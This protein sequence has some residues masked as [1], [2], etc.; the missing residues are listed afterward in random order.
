[1]IHQCHLLL[2]P[3]SV[4]ESRRLEPPR[5]KPLTL[6]SHPPI[7]ETDVEETDNMWII[8]TFWVRKLPRQ[9]AVRPDIF[10]SFNFFGIYSPNE[11]QIVPSNFPT[12]VV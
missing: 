12:D 6:I 10:V 4:T 2:W 5:P 9:A 11:P 1:M 8:Y 7:F 3:A